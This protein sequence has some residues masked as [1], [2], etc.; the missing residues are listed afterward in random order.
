M[1]G[2][3]RARRMR[4]SIKG[5]YEGSRAGARPRGSSV[6][7]GRRRSAV[8]SIRTA[9][10]RMRAAKARTHARASPSDVGA[11]TIARAAASAAT[12]RTR[13]SAPRSR[14]ATTARSYAI[15]MDRRASALAVGHAAAS[16]RAKARRCR[17]TRASAERSTE[18]D[19]QLDAAGPDRHARGRFAGLA[20]EEEQHR[21]AG[22]RRRACD[23]KCGP[24]VGPPSRARARVERVL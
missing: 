11:T 8:R 17:I 9:R 1:A 13:S 5:R 18:G 16:Y 3:K 10:S 14:R 15:R 19:R 4:R 22:D 21:A 24:D 12:R 2:A 6:V 7:A 20:F 23:Q